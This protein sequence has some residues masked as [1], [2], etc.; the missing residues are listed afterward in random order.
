MFYPPDKPTFKFYRKGHINGQRKRYEQR[1]EILPNQIE[2][3][4]H[5]FAGS[6]TGKPERGPNRILEM[7]EHTIEELDYVRRCLDA[8]N[9]STPRS[10]N[11]P[12]IACWH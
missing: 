12:R 3:Y 7:I 1:I 2:R 11:E 6:F 5:D 9:K 4:K 8:T 10:K